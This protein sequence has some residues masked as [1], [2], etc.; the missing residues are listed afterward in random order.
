M[1]TYN[2][3]YRQ[4]GRHAGRQAYIQPHI[5]YITG[6]TDIQAGGYRHAY[7]QTHMRA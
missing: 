7:I 3:T 2:N 5:T 6:R 4:A 1:N